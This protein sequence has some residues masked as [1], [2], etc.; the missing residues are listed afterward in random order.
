MYS[1]PKCPA[2]EL[3]TASI[4]DLRVGLIDGSVVTGIPLL[5]LGLGSVMGA[6]LPTLSLEIKSAVSL[7]VF[8]LHPCEGG[9]RA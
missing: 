3:C 9:H 7:S 1:T 8:S 5:L 6:L 2:T 4:L